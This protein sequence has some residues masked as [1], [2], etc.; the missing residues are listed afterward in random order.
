MV[1]T[2]ADTISAFDPVRPEYES[3]TKA[4]SHAVEIQEAAV[5]QTKM[6]GLIGHLSAALARDRPGADGA[7]NPQPSYHVP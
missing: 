2:S 4:G 6:L 1:Q 3:K 5:E 7:V